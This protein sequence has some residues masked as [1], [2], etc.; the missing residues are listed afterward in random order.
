MNKL[1]E[2]KEKLVAGIK[3]KI[4]KEC[5]KKTNLQENEIIQLVD[6]PFEY[7]NGLYTTEELCPGVWNDN[8]DHD[9]IYHLFG[10]NLENFYDCE[11][12]N[13]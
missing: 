6:C 10:N 13:H 1:E 9:S 12:I 11:I 8:G 3:I 2:L 4:G 7:D 5:S